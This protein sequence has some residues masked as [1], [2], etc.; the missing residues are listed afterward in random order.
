MI[1]LTEH[2][3][4]TRK[5]LEENNYEAVELGKNHGTPLL[6]HE[7]R[8]WCEREGKIGIRI[9]HGRIPALVNI[10]AGLGTLVSESGQ[11]L[12]EWDLKVVSGIREIKTLLIADRGALARGDKR[13]EIR[14]LQRE[15]DA[16]YWQING[17]FEGGLPSTER[18]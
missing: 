13:E 17:E 16:A 11:T 10:G 6:P 2:P 14:Q 5:F 7:F 1:I 12:E 15:L 4:I 9:V 18:M 3:S 8:E